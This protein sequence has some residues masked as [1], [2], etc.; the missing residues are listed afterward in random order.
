MRSV[1]A[2]LFQV[3]FAGSLLL[4][5]IHAHALPDPAVEWAVETP[6]LSGSVTGYPAANPNSVVVSA[7][8]RTARISGTGEVIFSVEFGPEASRGGVLDP[9]VADL[10]GDGTDEIITGH[11]DGLIVALDGADGRVI[12][13]YDL[14]TGLATWRMPVAADLDG[15]GTVEVL[16]GNMDGWMTCLNHNGTLRWRSRIEDYRLSTPAVGDINNDGRLEVVYGTSTRH[17]IAL[18]ADGRL[19]WDRFHPPLHMGRTKPLIADLDGDGAAEIALTSSMIAPVTGVLCLNGAD[20]TVKW[21][22]PTWHKA[23]HSVA[24]GRFGDGSPALLVGDKGD[25]VGAYSGDGILHWRTQVSGRG[26]WTPLVQADIDGDGAHEIVFTVRDN[27]LDG[28]GNAWYV[29]N[30]EGDVLGAYPGG[31][32]FGSPMVADVDGDGVLEVVVSFADG[33]LVCYTFGGP[34]RD[35]AVIAGD[36]TGTPRYTRRPA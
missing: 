12:W 34:A 4:T 31:R 15:D 36:S 19:L 26:I 1:K 7:G 21:E 20:G 35:D 18:D 11:N 33:Q 17:V 8:G 2:I 16:A 25:N 30:T 24:L 14:G 27:S 6:K 13:E 9:A 5:A 22:G 3:L 28:K 10:D 29:L 32:G 23:Y